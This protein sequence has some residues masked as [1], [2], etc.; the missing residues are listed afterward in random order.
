[1]TAVHLYRLKQ[2]GG[3]FTDYK[4]GQEIPVQFTARRR[5]FPEEFD[6]LEAKLNIPLTVVD[7]NIKRDVTAA[8]VKVALTTVGYPLQHLEEA[9]QQFEPEFILKYSKIEWEQFSVRFTACV[10]HKEL[11]YGCTIQH[12]VK[13]GDYGIDDVADFLSLIIQNIRKLTIDHEIG[14]YYCITEYC[15]ENNK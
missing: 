5:V 14:D 13:K 10:G 6:Q 4:P 9:I 3:Q 8:A 15:A 12:D 11:S 1:M 2:K 7:S